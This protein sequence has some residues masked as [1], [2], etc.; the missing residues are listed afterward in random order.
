MPET[1]PLDPVLDHL[2]H[3]HPVAIEGREPEGVHQVRVAARRLGVWL[4]LADRRVLAGDLRWL[5]NAAGEVRDLDVLLALSLPGALR[6]DLLAR[7]DSARAALV[8]D[9]EG[10]RCLGLIDALRHLPP[11]SIQRARS[12]VERL[13]KLVER[14]G[15]RVDAER[16][17][18]EAQ[19]DRLHSL[20]RALRR[21]RYAR[22]WIGEPDPSL[23]RLQT[24]LGD[25]ND[26]DQLQRRLGLCADRSKLGD[27]ERDLARRADEAHADA[28]AAWR[29]SR[30][31][32]LELASTPRR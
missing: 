30:E 10:P 16:K 21:L 31:H 25:L 2:R 32:V 22:E 1:I 11:L 13:V 4:E 23:K 9:L 29:R 14:R 7:Y 19:R 12:G 18:S 6:G 26:L 28:L 5:R 8:V 15:E 24:A 27:F 17:S 3:H 20:R